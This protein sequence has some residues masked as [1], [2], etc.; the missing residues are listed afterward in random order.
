MSVYGL[1]SF[2]SLSRD[3]WSNFKNVLK[4]FFFER[5]GIFLVSVYYIF[6]MSYEQNMNISQI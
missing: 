4:S 5:A 6:W 1:L 3:A 2:A